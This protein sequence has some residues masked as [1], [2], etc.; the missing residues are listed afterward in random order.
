MNIPSIAGRVQTV[1]GTIE[2]GDL[3]VTLGH[4]HL[5]VDLSKFP[6]DPAESLATRSAVRQLSR[7]RWRRS[8][9]W[10]EALAHILPR[11]WPNVDDNSRLDD[12][13]TAIDEVRMYVELRAAPES[14]IDA[15][16]VHR[17]R[18]RP[19]GPRRAHIQG[20]GRP[21][22]GDHGRVLLHRPRPTR[23]RHG[24]AHGGRDEDLVVSLF[25]AE[26][27]TNRR[28]R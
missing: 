21:R 17:H 24:R 15:T 23:E 20:V 2:P 14:L 26:I 11:A 5:L 3:G 27:A 28:R 12:V 6:G 25:L 8:W 19:R 4:E 9:A 13:Q 22:H 7:S 10:S 16:G 18:P 1:L